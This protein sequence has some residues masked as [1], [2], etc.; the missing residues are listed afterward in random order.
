LALTPAL[1]REAKEYGFSDRRLSKLLN[2]DESS[3]RQYRKEKGI[4]PVYKMVD[5][6]AAEFK[7]YTPYLYSTYEKRL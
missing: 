3:L 1:L 4:V 5:T 2:T 6:C 7:A